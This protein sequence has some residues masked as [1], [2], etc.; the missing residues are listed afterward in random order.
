MYKEQFDELWR[1]TVNG[2]IYGITAKDIKGASQINEFIHRMVWTSAWG[3]KK[4]V[5]PERKLLDDIGRESPDKA[6]QLESVLSDIK[7]GISPILYAGIS[8]AAAGI[9]LLIL[10]QGGWRIAGGAV[11]LIGIGITVIGALQSRI[12][13]KKAATAALAKAKDKCDKII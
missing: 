2:V 10:I 5:P 12:N 6:Q 9:I 7:I 13:P 4:L 8:V 11:G 1:K 3:N